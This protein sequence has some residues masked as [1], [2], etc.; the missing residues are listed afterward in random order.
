M[1]RVVGWDAVVG[2]NPL[3]TAGSLVIPDDFIDWTRRQPTT[4][5]ERRGLG[6]L[7]QSPAFCPQCRAV[8]GQYLPQAAPLGTY[9]GFDGPRR[10]APKRVCSAPGASMCSAA[11]WCPR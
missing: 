3:L 11:T 1:T 7:P 6:Y 10:P 4:Y 5:F 2:I 8:F 9:L